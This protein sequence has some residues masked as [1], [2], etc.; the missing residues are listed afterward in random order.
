MRALIIIGLASCALLLLVLF[1]QPVPASTG[2]VCQMRGLLPDPL[3]TQGVTNP[4]V[5]QSNIH[6][7][8]CVSGWTT[9]IRPLVSYTNALKQK[10]MKEYGFT[11]SINAH[12]E[13][14]LIPLSIGGHPTDPK[15]LWPQP[16]AAPNPKDAVEGQLRAK[17]CSGAMSLATAQQRIA[18]NW[19]TANN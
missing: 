8:I 14:H 1:I 17:V 3:C 15:N 7:T 18:T 5:T 6:S 4:N 13:D 11:D 16:D 10:Q 12:E 9:T 19:Q 2:G